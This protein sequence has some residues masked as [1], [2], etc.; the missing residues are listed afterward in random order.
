MTTQGGPTKPA[1]PSIKPPAAQA[2][3]AFP[4]PEFKGG[5]EESILPADVRHWVVAAGFFG[6]G[7][8][9]FLLGMD[10]PA[11]V[12]MLDFESKGEGIARQLGVENY[13]APVQDAATAAG[14][15]PHGTLVF[16]RVR[17]ILEAVPAGRFTV[18]ILDGLTNLQEGMLDKVKANPLGFGLKP[19]NVDKGAMGGAWPGVGKLLQSIAAYARIK[20]IKVI[21]VTTEVKQSWGAQGPILNKFEVKG[22]S[23]IHKMSV[24]TVL[25]QP[26]TGLHGRVP[27][28][29]V[30]KE[31]LA[32]HEWKDGRQVVTNRIPPKLPRAEMAEVYRMLAEPPDFAKLGPE[33]W[34]TEEEMEPFRKVISKDQLGMMTKYLEAARATAAEGSDDE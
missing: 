24:L 33:Y 21:G 9:T 7:K 12:L 1:A 22:Q 27:S 25:M 30:M 6:T 19:E 2:R 11:N 31:Q 29:L 4:P 8:T 17:Q 5:R 23:D 34:P 26:P 15:N 20:D 18:L 16:D 14:F 13:F 32:R 28:A 3:P 10:V